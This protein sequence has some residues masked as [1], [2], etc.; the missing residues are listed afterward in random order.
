MAAD[1]DARIA[2]FKAE[3]LPHEAALRRSLARARLPRA[4]V[5][6]LVADVLAR[7]YAADSWAGVQ[8]GRAYVFMIL[9]NLLISAARRRRIVPFELIGDMEA[10]QLAADQPGAEAIVS[11]REELRRLQA[12]VAA[13]P[14][15]AREVLLKRRVEGLPAARVA[16]E[17]GVG[18]STVDKHLAKAMALLTR[19]MAEHE[20]LRSE[21]SQRPWQ[22]IR[23]P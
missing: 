21:R 17:L 10:L 6:D 1:R 14:P 15:R 11:D 4:E 23:R 7:A 20:P 19:A 2:W 13:L 18:V 3:V 8:D 9:R 16:E 22:R 12:A 5:E